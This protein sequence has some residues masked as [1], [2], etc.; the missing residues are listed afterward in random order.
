[1]KFLQTIASR[2]YK[3]EGAKIRELCF[4]FPN[5][6][7][8]LFFQKYLGELIN[9]PI[10]S[11]KIFTIKDFIISVSGLREADRL[12]SL[13]KLY[14]IYKEISGTEESFD[15]FV[16]WGDVII[17]DFNDTDKFLADARL[18]FA[19]IKELKEIESDY[20]FL[21][22][23]QLEAVMSFWEGFLPIGESEKKQKFR[24]LW[25]VLYPLYLKFREELVVEKSG[26]EGMIFR[27][28]A[29]NT[30]LLDKLSE[31]REIVFVGLNALNECEN[32]ILKELKKQGKADFYWDYFGEFITD[33]SNK[34]SHF[35]N[36]NISNFPSKR[37]IFFEKYEIP[38]I[39]IIG[40]SSA[41]MQT[42]IVTEILE[43]SENAIENAVVLPDEK[44]LLPML[45]SIPEKY[46]DV[47]VTMGYPLKGSPIMSLIEYITEL[48]KD[49]GAYYYK[50]VLPIL[51]HNYIKLICKES[52]REHLNK[53]V[54]QNMIYVAPSFF[55]DDHL[56]KLIF[57]ENLSKD[58][59]AKDFCFKL[60]EILDFVVQNSQTKGI[61]KEFIYHIRV[62]LTRIAGILIPM[63]LDTFGR[64][65]SQILSTVSIP[66]KGEPLSGLQI[67][68]VLETRALDF[69][70]V[71]YCSLNEGTFPSS[72]QSNSF[73]P[74][75]LRRGFSLPVKE[76]NDAI[77][78]YHFY[79]S[80]YRAKNVWLL[81]DTRT[82]GLNTGEMSRFIMQM[83]Y[84]YKLPLK[85][86]RASFRV[87]CAPEKI[88]EIA[89]SSQVIEKVEKIF[90]GEQAKS[91]SATALGSYILC[92]LQF[93]CSYIEGV[94]EDDEISE[95]IESND[96]GSIFHFVME[97]LYSGFK[98]KRLSKDEI[99]T[100]IKDSSQIE[101]L[102]EAGFLEYRN[103]REFKGYNLLIKRLIHKYV[104]LTLEFD[105]SLA[106]FEY[107]DSEKR[108]ISK[109]ILEDGKVVALKGFIDRIDRIEGIKRIVD[110]KTGKGEIKYSNLEELF[111]QKKFNKNKIAFQML[112]YA[113]LLD[114][115]QP[116]K[117][118]PYILRNISKNNRG[119]EKIVD[120]T[121]V[122]QYKERLKLLVKEIFSSEISFYRNRGTRTCEWC[123]YSPI[124][125]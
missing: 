31:Y 7:S 52:A 83:K 6:R 115:K 90:F 38:Q 113:M 78:S 94:K 98:G 116:V 3:D 14:R 16:F 63:S 49:K 61:E 75:N 66:F 29:E 2:F 67:M 119:D 45:H 106:P 43:N 37:E 96:F 21:T 34:A 81:Y 41:V 56:L 84:H 112:F 25:Q 107:T 69:D 64:L 72:S 103:L 86:S 77:A 102:I 110:Y 82:E 23:T 62:S 120:E 26:Y 73:I 30:I 4:V 18:L 39:E 79:R 100:L 9:S 74:Y 122:E 108:V 101:K 80:I 105:L 95:E 91:L 51:K 124:C 40:V 88:V 19:N 35:M 114:E 59:S 17:D 27:H 93:Y 99:T 89:K 104:Q 65:L 118:A 28:V 57:S 13:F 36:G 87:K 47:N 111:D 15:D 58:T 92:P 10:F 20:S 22:Q 117:L 32:K 125:Y 24:A 97:K 8:G 109:L 60:L 54:S 85:E 71:I 44:M 121:E 53:I 11:P 50:R 33:S 46:P 12:D 42:K 5:R 76:Y 55:E 1:M 48:T 70:N 123:P 68:G